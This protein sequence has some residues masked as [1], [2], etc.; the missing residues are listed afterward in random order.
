MEDSLKERLIK[1]SEDIKKILNKLITIEQKY[2]KNDEYIALFDLYISVIENERK[3]YSGLYDDKIMLSGILDILHDDYSVNEFY[4]DYANIINI[5]F[6]S[7]PKRVYQR[8]VSILDDSAFKLKEVDE[9]EE[10]DEIEDEFDEE[11]EKEYKERLIELY[12]EKD[13]AN[14]FYFLIDK[15]INNSDLLYVKDELIQI[16]HYILFVCREVENNFIYNKDRDSV[17]LESKFFANLFGINNET[18]EQYKNK[19]LLRMFED[20]INYFLKLNLEDIFDKDVV[21]ELVIVQILLE[22]SITLADFS[23]INEVISY[24]KQSINNSQLYFM[25]IINKSISKKEE[26][27]SKCRFISLLR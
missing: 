15:R 4:I 13:I 10:Y 20:Q 18:Y 5:G 3:M 11:L 22:I 9:T 6:N 17:Y 1:T 19:Y 14:L 16:K 23:L 12:I 24:L 25:D 7:A 26:V 2:G 21:L 8:I 27:K